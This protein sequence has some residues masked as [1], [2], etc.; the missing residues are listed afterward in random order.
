MESGVL[1]PGG[2][3]LFTETAEATK[4]PGSGFPM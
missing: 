4:A 1:E 3:V 2:E